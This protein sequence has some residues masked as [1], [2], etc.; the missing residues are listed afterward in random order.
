MIQ[1]LIKTSVRTVLLVSCWGLASLVA[2]AESASELAQ[3]AAPA[4]A[5]MDVPPP[6]LAAEAA[7]KVSDRHLLIFRESVAAIFGNYI[8]KVIN[9]TEQKAVFKSR[10]M[11]PKETTDFQPTEGLE[12]SDVKLADNGVMVEKE[13]E[14][15]V[16]IFGLGFKAEG[17]GGSAVLSFV[18]PEAIGTFIVLVPR[19]G[20]IH[21]KS[22]LFGAEDKDEGDKD[23]R[24]HLNQQAIPANQ[25]FTITIEGIPE[26]RGRYW[27][28]GA[29]VGIIVLVLAAVLA[30][31]T[32]PRLEAAGADT[33]IM[34]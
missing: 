33:Y 3:E 10:I 13:V 22:P 2:L 31:R 26:G 27:A 12:P 7:V 8:F 24:A 20:P 34:N 21:L 29:A 4:A 5:V 18:A 6:P 14:P 23:Y 16:H 19:Q 30:W 25:A 28:L 32:R 11:L 1:G 17:S 15:G 9:S